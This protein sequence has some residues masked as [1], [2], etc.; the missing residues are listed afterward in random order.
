MSPI[1]AVNLLYFCHTAY[2]ILP[3]ALI[4]ACVTSSFHISLK[5]E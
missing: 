5:K 1:D 2:G 4:P 3:T